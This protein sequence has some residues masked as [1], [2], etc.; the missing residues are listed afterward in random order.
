[1]KGKLI[2]FSA[3]SGSGKTSIVRYLLDQDLHLE[4]SISACSRDKRI[5][6]SHGV[7]YYFLSV[8]EFSQRIQK[9]DFIEWEEVY[10]D[11]FY[12]TLRSEVERIRNN[13]QNVIFDIDVLGGLNIK[14]QFG[15]DALSIFVKAPS[16]NHIRERLFARNTDSHEK[17][18]RRMDRVEYELTFENQFDV[19]IVNDVLETA[20]KEAKEIISDFLKKGE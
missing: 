16:I 17:I 15:D 8:E 4:F 14:K 1:M 3:P 6:E 12:G 19:I 10:K 18:K 13:G 5:N 11:H 20:Q 7:D 9:E 2:I